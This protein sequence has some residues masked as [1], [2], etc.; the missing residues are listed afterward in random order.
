[1]QQRP[2]GK[3]T[4][5]QVARAM[6]GAEAIEIKATIPGA[7]IAAA[8]RRF[9]LSEHNDEERYIYFFDTPALDLLGAGIIVRCRRV[10]GDEHDSTIKFRPVD[11][12]RIATRW[13]RFRD[14][15]IEADASEASF[16]KSASFS[17]PVAR[18]L[19]KRVA[20]GKRPVQAVFTKEQEEFLHSV[21]ER[22]Q[23]EQAKT[24]WALAFYAARHAAPEAASAHGHPRR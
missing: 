22:D 4:R 11:P 7:Q 6:A 9:G 8:L 10:M 3:A 14:F 21:A 16:I 20:G 24:R 15:K 1:M 19:I 12:R 17:M 5:G 23:S 2:R 13:H 18:G